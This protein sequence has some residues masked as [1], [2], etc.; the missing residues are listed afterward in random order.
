MRCSTRPDPAG[1]DRIRQAEAAVTAAA[2]RAPRADESATM[3]R[4]A[5]AVLY[6][7]WVGGPQLGINP[8]DWPDELADTVLAAA[9]RA[10]VPGTAASSD[11][12]DSAGRGT[13]RGMNS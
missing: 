9:R 4:H 8:E 3:R 7:L 11:G 6:L 13:A 2:A 10:D 5:A 12:A 1:P